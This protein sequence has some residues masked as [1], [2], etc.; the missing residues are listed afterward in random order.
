MAGQ[1]VKLVACRLG[2]RES[3]AIGHLCVLMLEHI[4][5]TDHHEI[6]GEGTSCF[7]KLQSPTFNVCP[8]GVFIAM[9][10]YEK[11]SKILKVL[12]KC[13]QGKI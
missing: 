6:L 2:L 4:T 10:Q 13:L 9:L 12:R 3:V 11:V 1:S 7:N 5:L 8:G